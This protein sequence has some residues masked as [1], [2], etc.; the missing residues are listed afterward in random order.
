[1]KGAVHGDATITDKV[2][3]KNEFVGPEPLMCLSSFPK[4]DPKL[5]SVIDQL[6]V[7][8]PSIVTTIGFVVGIPN[9]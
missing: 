8:V 2:P 4:P 7:S 6:L 9:R 1:M 3:V 5:K